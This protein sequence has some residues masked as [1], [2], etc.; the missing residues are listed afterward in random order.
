MTDSTVPNENLENSDD[1][2]TCVVT[3]AYHHKYS[4]KSQLKL[5]KCPNFCSTEDVFVDENKT[6]IHLKLRCTQCNTFWYIC[7]NCRHQSK[8][9]TTTHQLKRHF[10]ITC[11]TKITRKIQ[12]EIISPQK[13]RQKQYL[14]QRIKLRYVSNLMSFQNSVFSVGKRIKC[15]TST[16]SS[17]RD[18]IIWL[19]YHN[20]S[21]IIL[22]IY[23]NLPKFIV[24]S[25]WLT[26]SYL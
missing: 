6:N 7:H 26:C 23:W 16:N 21:S 4:P 9:F 14:Q 1:L 15:I 2:S 24:I 19:D 12:N 20:I 17:T 11:K 5:F 22:R 3:S 8:H 25:D 18:H 13:K 10:Y